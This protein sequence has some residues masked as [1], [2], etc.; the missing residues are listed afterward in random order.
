MNRKLLVAS[1]AFTLAAGVALGSWYDDYEAGITAVKKGQWQTVVQKMTAAIGAKPKENDKERAYGTLFENYH[2]YYYRGVAYLNLGQYEKAIADLEQT[3][4]PGEENLGTIDSL[5]QRAK[6]KLAE[7]R[8][9]EPQPPTPVTP[10]P[11]PRIVPTPQPAGPTITPA[12][13]QQF[14]AAVNEA[15]QALANASNRKATSSPQYAQ[16]IQQ[17]ADANQKGAA[18]R[19]DDDLNVAIASANNAKLFADS[20]TAPG[21]VAT[22]TTPPPP[23]VVGAANAALGDVT[24]RVRSALESYF[25]GEFDQATNEFKSLTR[26][27][28]NNGWIFAF[29]GA[30]QYSQ[31]AFEA[32]E[33]YR[34]QAI[35]SFKKAKR[36]RFKNGL[37]DK[38]FSKRIRRAF[39]N[40]TAG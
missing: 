2:P 20:A 15:K 5:M 3:S 25:N 30:S 16:A 17:L 37:P 29:L 39:I 38:W 9:P 31:Y 33:A 28:P 19:S 24:K 11:Q 4:G 21:V 13:K 14:T 18:A 27:L 6:S 10:Q 23:K 22:A 8:T 34:A 1:I 40:E 12:V 7:A 26:E 32:D 36:L 35:E